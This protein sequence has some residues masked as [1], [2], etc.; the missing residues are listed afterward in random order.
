METIKHNNLI[1]QEVYYNVPEL[2]HLITG[3]DRLTIHD[4]SL[5][6]ADPSVDPDYAALGWKNKLSALENP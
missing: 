1:S 5:N 4:I 6:V 2:R 3:T